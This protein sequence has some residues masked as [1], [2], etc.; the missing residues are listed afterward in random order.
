MFFSDFKVLSTNLALKLENFFFLG[1]NENFFFLGLNAS[2]LIFLVILNI[3]ATLQKLLGN[4][5]LILKGFSV[6]DHFI[7]FNFM[8]F[9]QYSV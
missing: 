8:K 4:K 3:Q 1:L 7:S 5:S 9:G 2:S 6:F